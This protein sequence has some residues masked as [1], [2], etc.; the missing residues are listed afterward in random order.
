ME[1]DRNKAREIT[2]ALQSLLTHAEMAALIIA[3]EFTANQLVNDPAIC[4][5]FAKAYGTFTI[6]GLEEL[7][8]ANDNV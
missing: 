3:A 2:R 5:K 4:D 6:E 8:E 7:M 1:F